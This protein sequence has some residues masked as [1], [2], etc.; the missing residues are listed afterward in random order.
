MQSPQVAVPTDSRPSACPLHSIAWSRAGTAALLYGLFSYTAF[1]LVFTYAIGFVNNWLVPKSIDSGTPGPI[2]ASA[3]INAALLSLFVVQHTIMARPAFKRWWTRIIPAAIERSTFVL[4]ASLCLVLAFWLWQPMPQI[5]WSVEHPA[6]V[7]GISAI[8]LAGFLV[9]LYSSFIINHFD[10]FG[11]RQVWLRFTGRQYTHVGF[12]LR[13]PYRLVRHPLMVGFLIAFWA[14]PEMSLGR[15]LFA[16]LTTGYIFLGVW[17]EERDL[18][19]QHG[20]DY[21]D[22]RRRVRGLLPIPRRAR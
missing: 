13:G 9:V 8:S 16:I 21:L 15:L 1:F 5:V 14:A 19:A 6:A 20:D 17:F 11:L 2:L 3:L 22:Y 12:R 7:I 4:A 10:L 18:V